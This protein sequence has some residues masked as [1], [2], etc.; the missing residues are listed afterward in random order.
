MFGP[1][2]TCRVRN[3]EAYPV[4]I[5]WGN[6]EYILQPHVDTF[7][8]TDAVINFF[9]DP[10]STNQMQSLTMADKSKGWVV[11]RATEVRRLRVKWARLN[12]HNGEDELITPD[13]DVYDLLD[14]WVPTVAKDPLG[15]HVNPASFTQAD[16]YS[17]DEIISR[18]QAQLD[19]LIRERNL[20]QLVQAATVESQIP[21]DD[22]T[23]ST[24]D[25]KIVRPRAAN[26]E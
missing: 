2:E 9:G 24:P 26:D 7:V 20:G 25:K 23:V 11:D 6:I 16:E 19:T 1:G 10:R 17:R 4:K 13:V 14:E 18:M 22:S 5:G 8:P 12:T 15:T 3:N 21:V